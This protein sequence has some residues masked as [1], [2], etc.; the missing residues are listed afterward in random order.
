MLHDE[1]SFIL[2][3]YKSVRSSD[4]DAIDVKKSDLNKDGKLSKYE[5]ARGK[6]I[7][8]ARGG[9]GKFPKGA[10]T[11]EDAETPTEKA[12]DLLSKP[13]R[14]LDSFEKYKLG[15]AKRFL[16]NMKTFNKILSHTAGMSEKEAKKYVKKH[17]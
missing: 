12:P 6:A 3:K 7:D 11:D 8:K 1:I 14:K 10:K 4:E 15:Q 2:E 9:D 13:K 17:S 5:A 16:K